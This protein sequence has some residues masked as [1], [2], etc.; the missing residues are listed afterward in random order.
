MSSPEEDSPSN[1]VNAD[2]TPLDIPSS[3]PVL[4][5]TAYG[6]PSSPGLSGLPSAR[7]FDSGYMSGQIE[8]YDDDDNEDRSPD[9]EDYAI[10]AQYSARIPPDAKFVGGLAGVD[11]VQRGVS[12]ESDGQGNNQGYVCTAS[13]LDE[14]LFGDLSDLLSPPVDWTDLIIQSAESSPAEEADGS[15]SIQRT[16]ACERSK[17]TERPSSGASPQ[18]TSSPA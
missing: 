18:L 14:E 15:G 4:M 6:L 5:G 13:D 16:A 9:A 3:P 8:A 17:P 11:S 1:S 10:A 7:T 12:A 2:G